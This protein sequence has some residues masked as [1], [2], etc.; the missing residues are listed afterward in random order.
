MLWEGEM[1]GEVEALLE[2]RGEPVALPEG[3]SLGVGAMERVTL[4]LTVGVAEGLTLRVPVGEE[5]MLV[6]VEGD[7]EGVGE[8][9]EEREAEGER[10]VK[11]DSVAAAEALLVRVGVV[12]V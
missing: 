2:V 4:T 12:E 3:V 1:E 10:V 6:L 9:E 5:L 11:R 7:L 8:A